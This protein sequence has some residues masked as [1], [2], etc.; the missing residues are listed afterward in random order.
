[1]FVTKPKK[2]LS[3]QKYLVQALH[4][5]LKGPSDTP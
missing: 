4:K 3:P 5:N 1:M 2:G